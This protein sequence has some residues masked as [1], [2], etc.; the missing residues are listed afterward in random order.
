MS[1][2]KTDILELW[3]Q[4]T[5]RDRQVK[6]GASN[7]SNPC[8]R[9]LGD[10]LARSLSG[11]P[12]EPEPQQYWLGAAIGTAI[13]ERLETLIR[14]RRPEWLSE[15]KVVLGS[16]E[17]YGVV[18][19]TLDLYQPERKRVVDFKS[20]N[21]D[22]LK[23]MKE[24]LTT[25]PT[26]YDT[27]KVVEARHKGKG[28]LFQLMLYAR[29]MQDAGYEVETIAI[30]FICRDGLSDADLWSHEV[31]YDRAL[32]DAAWDRLTRMWE[33]LRSGGDP[34]TLTSHPQCYYCRNY[35]D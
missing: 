34:A 7:I 35:R 33:W 11:E 26:E 17:Q 8:S 20:T 19:S 4:P 28:Y 14:E 29:A 22:K 5:E 13:H 2:I 24:A 3:K 6:V 1:D 16:L 31:P 32:A 12:Y 9:C 25:E 23:A 15:R 30:L 21:R 27:T 18:K 10:D